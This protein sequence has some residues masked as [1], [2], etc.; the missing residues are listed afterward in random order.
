[1]TICLSL[2]EEAAARDHRKLGATQD[3]FFMHPMSPGTA[4]FQ[5]KG[6]HIYK[7]LVE[8]IR[9]IYRDWGFHEVITPNMFSKKLWER[10]GHWEH[11]SEDMFK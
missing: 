10:S 5:P 3:L 4:F 7:T 1:M 6:A 9:K 8:F 11:Y 2:Q